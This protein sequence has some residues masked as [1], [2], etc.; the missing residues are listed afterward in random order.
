MEDMFDIVLW[1]CWIAILQHCGFAP[2]RNSWKKREI[3][4][5]EDVID[6]TTNT[7]HINLKVN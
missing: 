4:D 6:D 1:S 2:L 7:S 3:E 5:A